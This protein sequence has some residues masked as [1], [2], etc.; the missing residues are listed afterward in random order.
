MERRKVLR[1]ASIDSL[2]AEKCVDPATPGLSIE[3]GAKEALA[4][5]VES[6]GAA[7]P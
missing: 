3:V 5:A 7:Q 6:P 1:P 2:K 4:I